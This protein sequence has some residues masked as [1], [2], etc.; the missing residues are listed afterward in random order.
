MDNSGV[1]SQGPEASI[2]KFNSSIGLQILFC[3][4]SHITSTSSS[5]LISRIVRIQKIVK[6]TI[7]SVAEPA[8]AFACKMHPNAD[9]NIIEEHNTMAIE[10][11]YIYMEMS[12]K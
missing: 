7:D 9:S 11:H 8:P 5:K 3:I 6:P 4:F 10:W 1:S 12:A 2:C